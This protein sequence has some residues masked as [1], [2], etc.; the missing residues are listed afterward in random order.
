MAVQGSSTA[1]VRKSP[2]APLSWLKSRGLIRGRAL[3]YGCG[4]NTWYGMH[5]YDPYWRPNRITGQFDTIVCNYVLNVV[6][7]KT[8]RDILHRIRGLLAPGGSAYISVRRDLPRT[9]A[10]GRGTFQR[11]VTLR[12]PSVRKTTGYEIYLLKR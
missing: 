5:G 8:Q 9:G 4:R 1:I 10:V 3:D 7:E 11:Y 12:L 6:P 2:P